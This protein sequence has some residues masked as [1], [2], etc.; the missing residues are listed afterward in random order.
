[1]GEGD[2]DDHPGIAAVDADDLRLDAG[3]NALADADHLPDLVDL[4]PA[5]QPVL[6]EQE[7]GKA[8]V[9]APEGV[10]AIPVPQEIVESVDLAVLGQLFGKFVEVEKK[11]PGKDADLAV[12]AL[13]AGDIVLHRPR[14]DYLARELLLHALRDNAALGGL[15]VDTAG[16]HRAPSPIVEKG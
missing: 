4:C 16:N 11:I 5:E 13:S 8:L 3:E 7:I 2:L 14:L 1:M 15:A 12:G 9:A 10:G 6:A